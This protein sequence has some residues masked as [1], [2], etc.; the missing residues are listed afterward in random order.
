MTRLTLASRCTPSGWPRPSTAVTQKRSSSWTKL[1]TT[2]IGHP[3]GPAKTSVASVA[4]SSSSAIPAAPRRATDRS[5]RSSMP[6]RPIV[7]PV[8][9]GAEAGKSHR[10]FHW[11]LDVLDLEEFAEAL[12]AALP[13]NTALAIAPP[14]GVRTHPAT[15]VDRHGPGPDL[16]GELNG[17]GGRTPHVGVEA[18]AGGIC[19]REGLAHVVIGNDDAH[20]CEQLLLRD[21]GVVGHARHQGGLQEEPGLEMAGATAAGHHVGTGVDGPR[22]VSLD[23]SSMLVGDQRAD[24]GRVVVG[25]VDDKSAH[26]RGRL[27]DEAVVLGS[28]D[29]CPGRGSAPLTG[30]ADEA[31]DRRPDG[32]AG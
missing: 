8:T 32:R 30:V 15:T 9:S 6:S 5:S 12:L 20:R 18:V 21:L 7:A 14:R 10:V 29:Q 16:A 26:E 24:D 13:A 2:P 1:T 11:P 19:Q 27:G 4:V 3:S 25:I 23:V 17:I 22:E 28:G 31:Q